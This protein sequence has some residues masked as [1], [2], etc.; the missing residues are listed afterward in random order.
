MKEKLIENILKIEW[1]MF[2][3]VNNISGTAPC[4]KDEKTFRIMRSS[5]FKALSEN[6]LQSYLDDLICAE[7]AGEN[8][9]TLKYARMMQRTSPEEYALIKESI[10]S[11][12]PEKN[13]YIEKIVAISI[14]WERALHQKY[15][16]LTS[17]SRPISSKDDSPFVTSSETYMRGELSTYSSNTLKSYH[18]FVLQKYSEGGNLYEEILLNTVREY[19]FNSLQQANDNFTRG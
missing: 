4:Q 8:L 12:E 17:R 14:E 2:S 18:E 13:I 6:I 16:E 5:Q 15:P 10:P 7:K 19:G 3:N 9:M 1:D 11:V